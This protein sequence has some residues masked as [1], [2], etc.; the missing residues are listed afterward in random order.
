MN[1][2]YEKL[3]ALSNFIDTEIN[4]RKKS[5]DKKIKNKE[6]AHIEL[7]AYAEAVGIKNA[8]KELNLYIGED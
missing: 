4:K 5:I 2:V 1:I 7:T 3:K 6:F 8:M